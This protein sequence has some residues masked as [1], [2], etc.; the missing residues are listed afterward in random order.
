MHPKWFLKD[1]PWVTWIK[2]YLDL[3]VGGFKGHSN[4]GYGI[5]NE[6]FY[7]QE[8]HQRKNISKKDPPQICT[9]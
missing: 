3:C 4:M 2:M 8:G 6:A 1:R 7:I 5:I 9:V